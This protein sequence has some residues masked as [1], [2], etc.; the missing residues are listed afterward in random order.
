MGGGKGGSDFDPKGKSVAEI[1]RF[2]QV[3]AAALLLFGASSSKYSILRLIC[4]T[5]HLLVWLLH[6]IYIYACLYII[7]TTCILWLMYHYMYACA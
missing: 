4:T 7:Y 1:R 5:V 3:H 6:H 2:C